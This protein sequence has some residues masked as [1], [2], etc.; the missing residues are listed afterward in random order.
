MTKFNAK[1][2]KMLKPQTL[3]WLWDPVV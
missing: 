3:L 2:L 1:P